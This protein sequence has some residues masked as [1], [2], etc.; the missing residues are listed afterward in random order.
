MLSLSGHK[1]HNIMKMG[2]WASNSLL[3]VEYIQEK[4]STFSA[5]ISTSM[6]HI[7]PFTNMEVAVTAEDLRADTIH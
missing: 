7:A 4:I 1:P 6:S 3:F 5:G 2:R